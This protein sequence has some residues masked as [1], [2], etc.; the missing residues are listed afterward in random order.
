MSGTAELNALKQGGFSEQEI[1]THIKSKGEA[2]L[3]GG[4]SKK[5][6]NEYFGIKEPDT[7]KI[8]TF[9]ADAFTDVVSPDDL[10]L[11]NDPNTSELTAKQIA[12]KIQLKVWGA[13]NNL[14]PIFRSR[15]GNSTVNTALNLHT[16]G[17]YGMEMNLPDP[18]NMGFGQKLLAEGVSMAAEIPTYGAGFALGSVT[19]GNPLVGLFTSGFFGSTIAEIYAD[20]RQKNEVASLP[21]F[22]KLFME[23]GRDVGIKEGLKFYAGGVATK[24]LGPLSTS[25][26]ANTLAFNTAMTG[27]G[28]LLGDELPDPEMFLIQNILTLPVGYS[29]AKENIKNTV[30]KTGKSQ[31]EIFDDMVKDRTIREDLSSINMK[32]V[33]AYPQTK[34]I[35]KPEPKP[36]V[37]ERKT[38]TDPDAAKLE[39]SIQREKTVQEFTAK[40][41]KDDFLYYGIDKY[42]IFKQV[43][44]KAK[45]MGIKDYE[46]TIDPYEGLILQSGLKGVAEYNIRYGTLD[47]FQKSYEKIGPSLQERVGKVKSLEELDSIDHILLG[48][49]AIEKSSQGFK[50][51]VDIEAAKNF[52]KKNPQ[53]IQKQKSIVDYQ[54]IQLKNLKEDGMLTEKAFKTMTEANKDYV[55]FH[56]VIEPKSGKKEFGNIIVN[57]LKPFKGGEQK[58]YSPLESV[59]NNT[60]LF[61]AIGERNVANKNAIDLILKIKEIDPTAFPEVYKSP[62][63][64]KET[65]VTSEELKKIGIDVSKLDTEILDGFSLFRKEQGY[66]K[67]TEIQIFRDGKREVYEVG[68]DFARAF[69]RLD[70]TVWDDITKYIGVP[71]KMLRAGATQINPE[72][73]YNNIPR[74]AFQS[75]ILSKTWHPPFFS[76]IQGAAILIKPIRTA[77]GY[78]P[79]FEQYVKS[80]AYRSSLVQ[81]DRNYFQKSYKDLFT[82]IKPLNVITKPF[83]IL[84]VISENS[85]ALNRIGNFKFSLDKYLKEGFELK[86]AIRKAGYDSKVNP[87][88]Y[89]RSGVASRQMNLV[90]AF[91]TARIGA[92]TSVVE[93]FKARP[94]ATTAKSLAYISLLSFYN[95]LQN[96]D[97]PDYQRLSQI[98]KDLFWNFKITNSSITDLL[99]AA[100]AKEIKEKGYFYFSL[101]KP[102][103]LGLLFGTGTER[104][105]DYYKTKDPEAIKNFSLNF[106]K[107]FSKSFIPIPDVGKPIFEAW[108]EKSLFTG[109]PIVPN[110]LKNLPAEYQVTQ[111]TTETSKLVGQLIRTITGDDF[112]GLSSPLQI[113]NA[114]RNWT[115]PVGNQLA[116]AIDKVLIESGLIDDPIKPDVP[117]HEQFFFRLIAAKNPDRN[118]QPVTDFYKE[119]EKVS[120]RLN[121]IKNFR[122]SGDIISA[123]KEEAK[124]PVN[125][126]DLEIA[127]K[128]IRFKEEQ[129]RNIFNA[130]GFSAEEKRENI[131]YLIDSI[132][133]ESIISLKRFKQK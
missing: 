123:D 94:Y 71:T 38:P 6:V 35:E 69:S 20:M 50:T 26:T 19:T 24:F 104:L 51:G 128:A 100:G 41:L 101:P 21:E 105:L 28:V 31:P 92:L 10:R 126:I 11:F 120:K 32:E 119:W 48:Q 64:T 117:I 130:K 79:I 46:K 90:S 53:L 5:E 68:K 73:M 98:R 96:H 39:S 107:D 67:P 95:W 72:F 70:R 17:K 85:E 129:I 2:L 61:R 75:S 47:S 89:L 63:R 132:I 22:W 99:G 76:T 77:L 115:G 40:E 59:V 131:T 62:L 15:L 103:E 84:R 57:P 13:D 91:F 45:K 116:K 54:Y 122:D 12:D 112:S 9:W 80:G 110:S 88:D 25:V 82:G 102:F 34:Q 23:K 65:R 108:S 83:E 55:T 42:N 14:E 43:V 52:A 60:Y 86:E 121:A 36:I 125:Y 93:A 3:G 7:R 109:Q 74:D 118:A 1:Q 18:Q 97:D 66:L 81:M 30:I 78:Q 114:I 27:A 127:F 4:F 111:H 113:D 29:I 33:R 106:I 56:R 124:L 44:D 58:I 8:E 49:R 16:G 133:D 87:V 37:I